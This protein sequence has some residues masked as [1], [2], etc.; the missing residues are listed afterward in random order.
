M[1]I[2]V[3]ITG[4][5]FEVGDRVVTNKDLEKILDTNDQWIQ[6]KI[7]IEERRHVEKEQGLS[8]LA[9]PA[10]RKA[11]LDAGISPEE[12]DLIIVSTI[13]PDHT[14]VSTACKLQHLLGATNA[15]A[16]DLSNGGC[17]GS[18]YGIVTGSKFISDGT[19]KNVLV[20]GGEIYSKF[21]NWEDRSICVYF[22][23]GVGAA[24]LQQ[25]EEGY[26]IMAHSLGADGSGYDA[27]A[28]PAGGSKLPLSEN[29]FKKGLHFA[30]MDGKQIWEFATRI[31]SESITKT[32]DKLK[33]TVNELDYVISHQANINIIKVGMDRLGMP[34][35]KTYTNISKYGNTGGASVF[36]ALCEAVKKGNIKKGD[37]IALVAFGGGLAY[38]S[39]VMKWF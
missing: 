29:T 15:A 31:F 26:G 33:L 10:A 11:L 12:L 39:V 9:L 6:E 32:L 37:N 13:T 4:L 36:I 17:P 8:D 14:N 28:A 1:S 5:G 25:V 38:G 24:V 35:S 19:Y 3:G 34:M 7:G 23:D 30:K 27:L 2:S 21:V 22:G 18:V 16:F 20:L